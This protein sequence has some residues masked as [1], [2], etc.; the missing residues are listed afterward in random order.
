M[1]ISSTDAADDWDGDRIE[2]LRHRIG[3]T[4]TEFGLRI[5]ACSPQDAQAR[6]SR[7]ESDEKPPSAAVVKHLERLDSDQ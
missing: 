5:F 1:P 6:V 3:D 4:Q 2:K 7:L